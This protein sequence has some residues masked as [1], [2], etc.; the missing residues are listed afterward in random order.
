[1]EF[2]FFEDIRIELGA[3]PLK[4]NF[5]IGEVSSLLNVKPHTLRYWEEEFSMLNPKKFH[6][7]QRLYFKK[8]L[9]I[10]CLIKYLLYSQGYSI[11][12]A[13]DNL[14]SYYRKWK[15]SSSLKER[16]PDDNRQL[17]HRLNHI[18]NRIS[19]S[20]QLLKRKNLWLDVS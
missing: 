9:E 17:V 7:G 5:K 1:M 8:D 20:K 2:A 13:R 19:A 4:L 11:K 16:V 14:F 15:D 3:L 12:G 6:N 18:L 10:L